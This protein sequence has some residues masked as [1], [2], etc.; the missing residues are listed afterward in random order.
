MEIKAF[1][2]IVHR[3]LFAVISG[4]RRCL[5][6]A[7]KRSTDTGVHYPKPHSVYQTRSSQYPEGGLWGNG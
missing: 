3:V 7:S 5:L 4:K 6:G 1:G 2:S